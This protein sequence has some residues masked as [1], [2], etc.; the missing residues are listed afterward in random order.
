VLRTFASTWSFRAKIGTTE[1][2]RLQL[3]IHILTPSCYSSRM[4]PLPPAAQCL[5]VRY[6]GD[7]NGA[8]WNCIFH[9]QYTGTPPTESELLTYA[10]GVGSDWQLH[11]GPLC[12][13]GTTLS[14]IQVTDLTSATA[15]TA[16]TPMGVTGVRTGT[17]LTAQVALVS[18]WHINRRYRGGHPRNY[19][20]GGVQGDLVDS[21]HWTD[22]F[23]TEAQTAFEAWRAA[24]NG[25]IVGT[26]NGV[27]INL[28][29]FTAHALRPVPLP[30]PIVSVTVHTRID[31]QRRR[32]GKEAA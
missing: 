3:C 10:L 27:L 22:I 13:I 30:T 19:W 16:E 12:P 9:V 6:A 7:A 32:L 11:I 14:H 25:R 26:A 24:I 28:S 23:V 2:S 4:P 17:A 31:S 18:S 29:Y 1:F 8:V 20:P 21:R 5:K 15:P